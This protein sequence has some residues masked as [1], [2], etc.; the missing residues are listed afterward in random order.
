V[1]RFSESSRVFEE[2]ILEDIKPIE[3]AC[4]D[5]KMSVAI[6]E[7]FSVILHLGNKLNHGSNTV[8]GFTLDS[9]LKLKDAK[10]FDQKTTIMQYLVRM[11]Q[12]HDTSIFHFKD[13]LKH[14]RSAAY[15]RGSVIA[16]SVQELNDGLRDVQSIFYD[17]VTDKIDPKR[18]DQLKRGYFQSFLHATQDR[19][20]KLNLA[21]QRM[22]SKFQSILRYFGEDPELSSDEFFKTLHS[23]STAFE[24]AREDVERSQRADEREKKRRARPPRHSISGTPGCTPPCVLLIRSCTQADDAPFEKGSAI[25]QQNLSSDSLLIPLMA[26]RRGTV[27]F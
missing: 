6:R 27:G 13:D 14:V 16:E 18:A 3:A 7:L 8:S 21:V 22:N 25:E 26:S 23:F 11:I 19:V 20:S 24:E 12:R 5:V 4:D 2:D 17:F 9:L 10:A 1:L 15:I